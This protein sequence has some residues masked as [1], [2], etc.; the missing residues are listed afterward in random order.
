MEDPPL[1]VAS[2]S[3]VIDAWGA[4]ALGG[5]AVGLLRLPSDWTP[6][7]IVLTA[8][9]A[10]QARRVGTS[11]LL[12]SLPSDQQTMLGR[13]FSLTTASHDESRLISHPGLFVR[14]NSVEEAGATAR[15]EYPSVAVRPLLS[16]V[17]P[18]V[19]DLIQMSER[20]RVI[21]QVAVDGMNGF[22]S[23]ER[24]VSS[25]RNEALVEGLAT[26]AG[27]RQRRIRRSTPQDG[28]L[29]ANS[30]VQTERQL[31]H[32]VGWFTD[33]LTGCASAEWVWDGQRLWVVQ[34]D[35]FT[36]PQSDTLAST[37]LRHTDKA[38]AT[39]Y[40][41]AKHHL[42]HFATIDATPWKKLE[43]AQRLHALGLP[44]TDIYLILGSE[45][46]EEQAPVLARDL[47]QRHDGLWVIRT[48]VSAEAGVSEDLLPTSG[49]TADVNRLISFMK[50]ARTTFTRQGLRDPNWAL[51]AAPLV[52]ARVS[53]MAYSQPGSR[54]VQ[55]DALWGFPDGLMY[56]PH[57]TYVLKANEDV[58]SA[59]RHKP[60]CLLFSDG[61]WVTSR[62]GAPYDWEQTLDESEVRAAGAWTRKLASDLQ[63]AVKAMLLFRVGGNRGPSAGI[64]F[65]YTTGRILPPTF[66]S[67]RAAGS[68]G[69]LI[70]RAFDDLAAART[71]A[72]LQGLIIEPRADLAR[73]ITFLKRLADTALARG[74]P[75]LF[76]GSLLSHS[77]HIMSQVGA[78]VVPVDPTPL[79][80]TVIE[81]R[82]LVRDSIPAII[83]RSGSVA[84]VR[85]LDPGEALPLLRRKLVEEALEALMSP[86]SELIG[87][88]ADVREVLEALEQH[89]ENGHQQVLDAMAIKREQRGAFKD[90]VFLE[91]TAERPVDARPV[92]RP[93]LAHATPI[94]T[95]RSATAFGLD[96]IAIEVPHLPPVEGHKYRHTVEIN[97]TFEASITMEYDTGGIRVTFDLER[98][99]NRHQ[100]S[101]FD[102]E[103]DAALRRPDRG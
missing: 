51:L 34:L 15:G 50:E 83:E 78:A 99:E 10:D 31:R 103:P 20:M 30:V 64:A 22:V 81:Y 96:H 46:T 2:W 11:A 53:A 60:A 56:L 33:H 94:A 16:E 80:G 86:P 58:L 29:L 23:N 79:S 71:K 84:R 75:V 92:W 76:E 36:S 91:A 38:R 45:C 65:H 62:L 40:N 37:Y 26:P 8:S 18:A 95:A 21:L 90:L 44:T 41:P 77:Y 32:V 73:D 25:N 1:L 47:L 66:D 55:V 67:G 17:I 13:L 49:P 72:D 27:S 93:S 63:T 101:L 98:R 6:P 57:D 102:H 39:E 52:P 28:P 100:L 9:F 19:Q 14:S 89:I 42:R 68:R 35:E 74:V 7:F 5:K 87:E 43:R 61:N 97:A 54:D 70:V 59:V 69:I 85:T 4:D 24:R 48:D 82:K 3:P 12:E 88:L